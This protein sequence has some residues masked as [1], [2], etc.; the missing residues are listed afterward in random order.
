MD[1]D[2]V[3]IVIVGMAAVTYLP[4]FLPAWLLSSRSL[5]G[6]VIAWLKHVPAA[7]LSAM[8]FP[9]LFLID[10]RLDVSWNN[11]YLLAA[12]P[13]FLVAWKAKSLFGSILI[14]MGVVAGARY[15]F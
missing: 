12:I 9:G 14:G 15:F 4:R 13:T 5:P 6:P 3:F 2:V 10:G 7:V 8:L 1:Q 11:L